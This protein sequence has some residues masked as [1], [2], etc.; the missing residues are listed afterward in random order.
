M[1]ICYIDFTFG[2][3]FP[4]ILCYFQSLRTDIAIKNASELEKYHKMTVLLNRI[5]NNS[6]FVSSGE[7]EYEK[8][9]FE[10][11]LLKQSIEKENPS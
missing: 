7:R 10:F 2:F 1:R 11:L 4:V 5:I 9:K 6:N 8:F 3:H